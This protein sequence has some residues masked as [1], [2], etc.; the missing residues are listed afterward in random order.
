VD[1]QAAAEISS[2][3]ELF[4][5]ARDY[6]SLLKAAVIASGLVPPGMEGAAQ[7]LADILERLTGACGMGIEIVSK[8]NGIPKGSRLAVSTTLMASLIAACMRSTGQ[9]QSLEGG[10]TEEERS[11]VAARAILGEWLGGSGGG[12][13]DSGGVWPGIKLIYGVTAAEGDPEFGVSR[14][15]L[16]PRHRIF[17]A[18]EITPETRQSLQSRQQ[19]IA[20]GSRLVRLPGVR[21]FQ[22]EANDILIAKAQIHRPQ[23]R[24]AMCEKPGQRHQHHA[25]ARVAE[26]PGRD[27][28][29][30]GPAEEDAAAEV[31]HRLGQQ[32]NA[33]HDDGAD[34]IDVHDRI[35]RQPPQ[36]LRRVVAER[37][38]GITVR[39]LMQDDRHH[40]GGE[41]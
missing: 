25:A 33:G 22:G 29:R 9:I 18:S 38:R 11:L 28:H 26:A 36:P 40:H 15:C 1:L 4:D 39:H 31:R 20:R 37:Q 14:G 8:V 13:Q 3:D 16:L 30:F 19:S 6:L 34:L 2:I 35:E 10:L 32:E 24:Q 5:F 21:Y 27:R 23:R 7:P 17:D 12:W 41:R